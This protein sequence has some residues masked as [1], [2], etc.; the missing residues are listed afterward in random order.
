MPEQSITIK[1]KPIG[2]KS[3]INS[4]NKLD[5]ATKRLT[6]ENRQLKH[7][8]SKTTKNAGVLDTRNKR[9]TNTNKD[10]GLSF[11][12]LRSKMLLFNFAMALGIRQV[13]D[14]GRQAAAVNLMRQ[15]FNSLIDPTEKSSESLNK[16]RQATNG[17]VSD[18]RLLQ[19]ANNAMILGVSKNTDEM[20]EMF[21]MAQRLGKALGRDTASS[22]ESL[23]TGVG[24]QSR[25]MLDN[26]GIIVKVDDAQK[27]YAMSLNKSV[28]A[29]TDNEKKQAF[30]NAVMDAAR[31]KVEL[32]GDEQAST[33]ETFDRF[34]A[35]SQNAAMALGDFANIFLEPTLDL[36][37]S[38]NETITPQNVR[39][40]A[41]AFTVS[42]IPAVILYNNKIKVAT[43]LTKTFGITLMK[44][45]YIAT[46]V[47]VTTLATGVLKLVDAFEDAND[48]TDNIS[49]KTATYIESLKKLTTSQLN[50]EKG[51]QN[52]SIVRA[53]DTEEYEKA[54]KAIKDANEMIEIY[55][56]K[57][58]K[59][60]Q[61]GGENADETDKQI[62]N[63]TDLVNS[64]K[65]ARDGVDGYGSAIFKQINASKL[66]IEEIDKFIS[67]L[68]DSDST[69]ENHIS[70]NEQL[71]QLFLKTREGRISDIE[72]MIE[73]VNTNAD[74]ID[75]DEKRVAVL[76][77]L[78]EQLNKTKEVD[79]QAHQ[80]KLKTVSASVGALAK[81]N[82]ASSGSAKATARLM[83]VQ[84]GIDAYAAANRA[85]ATGVPP[86]SYIQAATSYALGLANVIQIEK[87]IGK[88]EYGGIIGGRRHSQGGTIIE[89]EQGEFVMSRNAV[90]A[91]GIETMNRI[92]QTGSAGV[93]V[94]VSGNVM[95][96]DFV[97]GELA[98]RIKEA[99]RKGS[100]FGMS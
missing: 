86:M 22:V 64:Y 57:L 28:S 16:L 44:N 25:L 75:S 24:R 29:L 47:A 7:E 31:K 56:N 69:I 49:G 18:F 33:T 53:K 97:E 10:L 2:D 67:I 90:D 6:G 63:Y 48:V 40:F 60:I 81:L 85:L 36:M 98:E 88:F 42:L 14:F 51:S 15:S 89:A 62:K 59:T 34:A 46:T 72:G 41:S 43:F 73:F 82:Q 45:P 92:N 78:E 84:A 54:T 55:Q 37:S 96:Q 77:M 39:I 12:T 13:I 52:A 66:S 26:I 71:N 19:Q 94:N 23:I 61:F 8:L 9:L 80:A 100:N 1:F 91:V 35:T 68:G 58:D 38:F 4:I 87:S 65:E 74:L 32:L 27:D 11:A 93:T 79:N 95:S 5:A 21:D 50:V 99:V 83:Q 30:Q 76:K 3:L 17:T 70:V 20:A